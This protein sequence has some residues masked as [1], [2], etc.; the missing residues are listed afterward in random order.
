MYIQAI[1]KETSKSFLVTNIALSLC[2]HDGYLCPL[3]QKKICYN[4]KFDNKICAKL[5]VL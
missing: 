2:E 5:K 1:V 4:F 3:V